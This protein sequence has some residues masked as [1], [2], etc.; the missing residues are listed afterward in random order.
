MATSIN[1]SQSQ[2]VLPK[3]FECEKRQLHCLDVPHGFV[4]GM[5]RGNLGYQMQY[6]VRLLERQ[7]ADEG[8]PH[9]LQLN[10]F[11][12]GECGWENPRR[13]YL[14]ADGFE[15]AHGSG[16]FARACFE[17]SA[18]AFLDVCREAVQDAGLSELDEREFYL[19]CRA[20]D[21]ARYE[22]FDDGDCAMGSRE[23]RV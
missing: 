14:Y 13:W 4:S 2:N 1:S 10:A 8:H 12:N 7:L 3:S 18:E 6:S 9:V 17:D 5:A 20:R 22:P 23:G 21:I 11:G 15:V 19:L 16:E